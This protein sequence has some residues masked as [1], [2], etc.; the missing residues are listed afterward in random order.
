MNGHSLSE[1]NTGLIHFRAAGF[2]YSLGTVY[3]IWIAVVISLYPV[4]KKYDRLKSSHKKWWL[5]YL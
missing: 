5:S 3:L 2:G 1:A 4:C